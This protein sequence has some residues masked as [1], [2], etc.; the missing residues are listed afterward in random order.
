MRVFSSKTLLNAYTPTGA[1]PIYAVVA[2]GATFRAYRYDGNWDLDETYFEGL[3][4]IVQPQIDQVQ[5]AAAMVVESFSTARAL[6]DAL[7]QPSRLLLGPDMAFKCHLHYHDGNGDGQQI[8][9]HRRQRHSQAK[10]RP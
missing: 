3:A 10:C 8:N 5:A 4:A 7:I 1:E 6:T 2:D 9:R